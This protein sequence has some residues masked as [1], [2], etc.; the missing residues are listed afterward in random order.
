MNELPEQN[1]VDPLDYAEEIEYDYNI[2]RFVCTFPD[3]E[4]ALFRGELENRW[5]LRNPKTNE[6][7]EFPS[8][9]KLVEFR[10]E[11][12]RKGEAK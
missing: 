11:R 7:F 3:G 4:V 9:S 8:Y 6:S 1:I 2:Q 10:I 12:R 5:E